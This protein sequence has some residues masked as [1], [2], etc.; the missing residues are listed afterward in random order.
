LARNATKK[1]KK[2]KKRVTTTELWM[3]KSIRYNE[4]FF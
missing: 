1:Y 2:G 3:I 4:C